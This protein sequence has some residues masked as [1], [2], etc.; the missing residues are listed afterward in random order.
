MKK[1]FITCFIFFSAFLYAQNWTNFYELEYA[2]FS[3]KQYRTI[4]K[5]NV[6]DEDGFVV[7]IIDSNI[8]FQSSS[9]AYVQDSTNEP[10]EIFDHFIG[11][12]DGW[13]STDY[14]II[15]DSDIFPHSIITSKQNRNNT[16]WIPNWYN[17]IISTNKK[18]EDYSD[19]Y[20]RFK[21]VK[22]IPIANLH[23]IEIRNTSLTM[24]DT[25]R[26][27]CFSIKNIQKINNIYKVYCEIENGEQ[28][29]YYNFEK[30][31]FYNLPKLEDDRYV[32]FLIE[33][34]GNRIRFY[35]SETFQ[36][37]VE[38]MQIDKTW[39]NQMLDY[40]KSKYKN[41]PISLNIIKEQIDHD[42][43]NVSELKC[44]RHADGSCDYDGTKKSAATNV[45]QNKLMVVSE[46]LKL[47]SG[48]ATTTPVLTVMS[49]GTKVKILEL[50][51]AE[52]IDG[53]SSNWVKVEVQSGA[54]DRDGKAINPGTVGWCYGGYLK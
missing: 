53:I 40:I 26:I 23:T 25:N 22:E 16:I 14:L 20:R 28:E 19:W 15:E 8:S 9:L 5:T 11:F 35:N 46:N 32:T 2:G 27:I 44:P 29:H 33:A 45:S 21:N 34:N 49:A 41:K 43:L 6:Y 12:K 1:L 3:N 10:Y 39:K 13:I 31:S 52:T 47:R 48:E 30:E 18:L 51:K 54:K 4:E 7:E 42:W 50:G 24:F 36:L 38:L 17:S 37:I